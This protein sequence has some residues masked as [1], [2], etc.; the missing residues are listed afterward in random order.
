MKDSYV[1]QNL[2]DYVAE[3]EGEGALV[4][5]VGEVEEV[6]VLLV[7]MT[8]TGQV[9]THNHPLAGYTHN[10]LQDGH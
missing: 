7:P 5:H 8:V 3:G 6:A 4:A 10:N 1:A 9:D 2:T